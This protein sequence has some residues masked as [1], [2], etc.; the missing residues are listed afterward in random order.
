[1]VTSTELAAVSWTSLSTVHYYTSLG[2][3]VA[4]RRVGN[5]RLY[6]LRD[7]KVRLRTIARLRQAEYPLNLIREQLSHTRKG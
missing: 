6:D 5:K 2:L 4:R 1:M 7:S 3:L